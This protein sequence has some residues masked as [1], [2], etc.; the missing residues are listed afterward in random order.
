MS[1]HDGSDVEAGGP[2]TPEAL[3][4]VADW[5]DTHDRLSHFLLDAMARTEGNPPELVEQARAALGPL[6][7]T[8]VQDDLRRWARELREA[9]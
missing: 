2:L 9:S 1:E 3:E 6:E 5:M 7:G 4:A 8:D